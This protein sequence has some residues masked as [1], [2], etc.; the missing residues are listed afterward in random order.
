[1]VK[2]QSEL[3]RL[4][5]QYPE[6]F[7]REEVELPNE[8]FEEMNELLDERIKTDSLYSKHLRTLAFGTR[9]EQMK[10]TKR[11]MSGFYERH[12]GDW[13]RKTL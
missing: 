8:K 6:K 13:R 9:E 2:A 3:T 1:M 7:I 12:I 11:E 5:R 4:S 10:E